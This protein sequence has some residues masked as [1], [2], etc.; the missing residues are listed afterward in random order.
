[1]LDLNSIQ[2]M[3]VYEVKVEEEVHEYD[4]VALWGALRA[5]DGVDD[6]M[7][8]HHIVMET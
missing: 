2:K 4:A 3:P 5:L 7:Q 6:P 8:I 1:M